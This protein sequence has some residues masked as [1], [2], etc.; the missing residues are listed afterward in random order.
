MRVGSIRHGKSPNS[1]PVGKVD[2]PDTQRGSEVSRTGYRPASP[3]PYDSDPTPT[4]PGVGEAGGGPLPNVDETP[5]EAAIYWRTHGY[6]QGLS[7]IHISEPTRP[8]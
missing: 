8:Y 6:E 7:L 2:R 4:G 3:T 1:G 5:I